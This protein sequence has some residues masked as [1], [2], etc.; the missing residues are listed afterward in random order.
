MLTVDS[1]TDI[2]TS[3]LG[4]KY[5]LGKLI[6][7][8]LFFFF[9]VTGDDGPSGYGFEI[10]FRL[11]REVDETAPPTWPAELMQSLARYV[12]QSG[13]IIFLLT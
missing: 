6:N 12:F 1:G 7:G 4:E 8:F 10:T 13:I 5:T 9:S 11:K 2:I 3:L